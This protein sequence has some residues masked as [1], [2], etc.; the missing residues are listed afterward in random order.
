[1]FFAAYSRRAGRDI[2][3]TCNCTGLYVATVRAKKS[4]YNE[5]EEDEESSGDDSSGDE[6]SSPSSGK[7]S[8]PSKK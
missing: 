5:H 3:T 7:P 2:K 4:F 6:D 8:K 1:M